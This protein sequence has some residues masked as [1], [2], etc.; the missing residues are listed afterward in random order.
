ML[1]ARNLGT[2]EVGLVKDFRL[3]AELY[4]RHHETVIVTMELVN[5][6]GMF[7]DRHEVTMLVDDT[8]LTEFQQMRSLIERDLFLKLIA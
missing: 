6:I 8:T 2:E 7:A 1:V 5:L 3:A 4:L